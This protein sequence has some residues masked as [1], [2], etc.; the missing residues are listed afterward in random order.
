MSDTPP[1]EAP[2][3]RDA[4]GGGVTRQA[5][6]KPWETVG[7]QSYGTK[8]RSISRYVRRVA[9]SK[10]RETGGRKANIGG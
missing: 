1:W 9:T 4:Y 8:A 3:A 7:L 6:G 10:P 2:A 5:V